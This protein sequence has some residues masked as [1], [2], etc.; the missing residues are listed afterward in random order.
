[1]SNKHLIGT[2]VPSVNLEKPDFELTR[3]ERI[4]KEQM[5]KGYASQGVYDEQG[6]QRF[7]G[8]FTGGFSAGYYNTVGSKE[9]FTPKSYYS[10]RDQRAPTVSQSIT[11]FM[12]EEDL[13][14]M[15]FGGRGGSRL[16]IASDFARPKASG[17]SDFEGRL[18]AESGL[19]VPFEL[20][21][22]GADTV[23]YRLLKS[24]GW[25]EGR[26]VGPKRLAITDEEEESGNRFDSKVVRF[27]EKSNS[28]G[29]GYNRLSISRERGVSKKPTLAPQ[30]SNR[31]TMGSFNDD[32]EDDLIYGS[33]KPKFDSE[34]EVMDEEEDGF[35]LNVQP[36]QKKAAPTRKAPRKQTLVAP[37]SSVPGFV[38][39]LNPPLAIQHFAPPTVPS[40]FNPMHRLPN[41]LQPH[42]AI[43]KY[44][45]HPGASLTSSQRSRILD[46][47]VLESHHGSAPIQAR[48]VFSEDENATTAK[49]PDFTLRSR[50][51]SDAPVSAPAVSTSGL[52][53]PSQQSQPA[54]VT[55]FLVNPALT[56]ETL[57]QERYQRWVKIRRGEMKEPAEDEWRDGLNVEER[58][59]EHSEFAK[60]WSGS[61]KV[62]DLMSKRFTSTQEKS[63]SDQPSFAQL[64]ASSL[65]HDAARSGAFGK[66]TRSVA[67]WTPNSLLCKRMN[68]LKPVRVA[69]YGHPNNTSQSSQ[70]GATQQSAFERSSSASQSHHSRSDRKTSGEDSFNLDPSSNPLL[71]EDKSMIKVDLSAED[72]DDNTPLPPVTRPSMDLFK[73]IFEFDGDED[74]GDAHS[75]TLAPSNS[76][77][78]NFAPPA[79]I[80]TEPFNAASF[81]DSKLDN[82]PRL[83]NFPPKP[84]PSLPPTQNETLPSFAPPMPSHSESPVDS[85]FARLTSDIR[86]SSPSDFAYEAHSSVPLP[87]QSRSRTDDRDY[88]SDRSR[89][90]DKSRHDHK[91]KDKHRHKDKH[92]RDDKDR[93]KSHSKK[94]DRYSSD[95]SDSDD[96][97]RSKSSKK[98]KY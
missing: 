49:V 7:H 50:F 12:D 24:M 25:S 64:D 68:V 97:R 92:K 38:R 55:S 52:Y 19:F 66:L 63:T 94:R 35:A 27:Q 96:R 28:H 57:K 56:N 46:E 37:S 76:I 79:H 5:T 10:S 18:G 32:D 51:T 86:G 30:K 9:G 53:I 95:D 40:N 16:Q 14:D 88:D 34:F 11:D 98:H 73:S 59:A 23:G 31:L 8:A 82:L 72:K 41:D 47:E 60:R 43:H 17:S 91:H 44:S 83:L 36:K 20:I 54:Q 13:R 15:D 71:E 22:H 65:K 29:L 90:K 42:L 89:H 70:N 75:T 78:E 2:S 21:K 45:S 3:K 48:Q 69:K 81:N 80:A 62:A 6:R 26:A 85:F 61:E 87:P 67:E 4:A 84:K 93:H 1:M 74:E 39:A 33:S 77:T 58:Q